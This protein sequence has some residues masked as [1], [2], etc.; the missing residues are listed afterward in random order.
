[1]CILIL[2][3]EIKYICNAPKGINYSEINLEEGKSRQPKHIT[4]MNFRKPKY[5]ESAPVME[6]KV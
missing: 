4:E 3:K 5:T 2:N 6:L 1:M